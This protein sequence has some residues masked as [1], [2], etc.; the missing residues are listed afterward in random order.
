MELFLLMLYL[1]LVSILD[2]PYPEQKHRR[3]K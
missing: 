3:V 2:D 1:A